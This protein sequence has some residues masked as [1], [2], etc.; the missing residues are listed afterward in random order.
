MNNENL[1]LKTELIYFKEDVLKDIK[2]SSLKLTSRIDDQKDVFSRKIANI[3][4]RLEALFNKVVSLANSIS[5][6]KTMS[7]KIETLEKFRTKAQDTLFSYDLN[8]KAQSKLIKDNSYRIESFINDNIYYNG[9]IG[10]TNNCKF[11]SFH[12]FID[13]VLLNIAQLNTFK[14]KN[15]ALDFK[16]YKNKIDNNIEMMKIELENNLNTNTNY[17]KRTIQE[18]ENKTKNILNSLDEKIMQIRLENN[19]LNTNIEKTL[20]IITNESNKMKKEIYD[21]LK[22]ETEEINNM[23]KFID[24]KI[25]IYHKECLDN[26]EKLHKLIEGL[27]NMSIKDKNSDSK[28]TPHGL[29]SP[30]VES[31]LKKYIEG[32]VG[33]D[34]VSYHKNINNN[35]ILSNNLVDINKDENVDINYLILNGKKNINDINNINNLNNLT[36]NYKNNINIRKARRS[37][38]SASPIILKDYFNNVENKYSNEKF[39]INNDYSNNNFTRKI[40]SINYEFKNINKIIGK[41]SY[42]PELNFVQKDFLLMNIQKN[43]KNSN[44]ILTPLINSKKDDDRINLIYTHKNINNTFINN[45]LN[46]TK[47]KDIKYSNLNNFK[48]EKKDK[49]INK[50]IIDKNIIKNI[51]NMKNKKIVESKSDKIIFKEM[52]DSKSE[53][54]IFKEKEK[55]PKKGIIYHNK[56]KKLNNYKYIDSLSTDKDNFYNNST[57]NATTT[58]IKNENFENNKKNNSNEEIAINYNNVQLNKNE[59]NKIIIRSLMSGQN[60]ISKLS[61]INNDNTSNINDDYPNPIANALEIKNISVKNKKEKDEKKENKEN[62]ESKEK[63]IYSYLDDKTSNNNINEQESKKPKKLNNTCNDIIDKDKNKI[64]NNIIAILNYSDHNINSKN[65]L[66]KKD[67]NENPLSNKK[68]RDNNNNLKQSNSHKNIIKFKEKHEFKNKLEIKP[69]TNKLNI[70]N[71]N[72]MEIIAMSQIERSMKHL[73]GISNN[74]NKKNNDLI[75]ISDKIKSNIASSTFYSNNENIQNKQNKI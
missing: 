74:T 72:K 41:D 70:N 13:Y 51:N 53:K 7:E 21:N 33:S 62:K 39:I 11:N 36:N 3:E 16:S 54:T 18:S 34:E 58:K 31:F 35:N 47:N 29:K 48:N 52:V 40:S 9:I 26:Y 59:I 61:I 43:L 37:F 19:K 23:Y 10:N 69:N 65:K 8:F 5:I 71:K 66:D 20:E 38:F 64:E 50:V 67:E 6:D 55:E 75:S 68:S 25:E 49:E 44:F 14:D 28:G 73:S 46:M 45:N 60:S 27:I 63:V 4:T 1:A 17:T 30:R 24:N 57:N 22:E 32:K 2:S 15:L 12:K 42:K 56:E